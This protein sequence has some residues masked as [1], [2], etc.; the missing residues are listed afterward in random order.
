[1]LFGST[2]DDGGGAAVADDDAGDAGTGADLRPRLPRGVGHRADEHARSALHRGAGAARRR[3]DGRVEEKHGA[4]SRRPRALTGGEDAGRCHRR[5]HDVG[6]EPFGD[7]VRGGHRH[8][9]QEPVLVGPP[10][11]AEPATGLEQFPDF[12]QRRAVERRRRHLE[13]LAE[14][15]P[16]PR[17]RLREPAVRAGVPLGEG[18]DRL[19]RARLV[20]RD[21]ERPP[22]G[23]ERHEPRVGI[24]ELHASSREPHVAHDGRAKRSDRVR[25]RRRRVAGDELGVLEPAADRCP[26]LDD[27]DGQPR[28]GEVEGGGE[29]VVTGA[30][31]EDGGQ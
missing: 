29:A 1:V 15:R 10:E 21:H 22:V 6:R 3:I 11:R 5:L 17:Q 16:Q 19:Q 7:E 4:R 9:A 27:D 24:H 14:K 2:L 31:D 8:P 28:P 13:D 25:D 30:D 18:A 26:P 20:G 12:A 23:G